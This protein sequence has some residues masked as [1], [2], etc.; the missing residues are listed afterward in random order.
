MFKEKNVAK[1]II[2]VKFKGTTTQWPVQT[3]TFKQHK[4][5]T[6]TRRN[7]HLGS[8]AYIF[9]AFYNF[10]RTFYYIITPRNVELPPWYD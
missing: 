7:I 3:Q 8:T 9:M 4:T 1:N 5:R 6:I 2:R 10:I